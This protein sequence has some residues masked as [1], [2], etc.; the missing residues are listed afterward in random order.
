MYE[1]LRRLQI[2]E[3]RS[4]DLVQINEDTYSKAFIYIEQL[5]EKLVSKW[6]TQTIRELEN[7]SKVL[8][9]VEMRRAEKIVLHAFNEIYNG[10]QP[11]QGLTDQEKA[12]YYEVKDAIRRFKEGIDKREVKKVEQ[13]EDVIKIKVLK[14]VPKFKALDGNEY[15]PFVAG[16]L[17]ELPKNEGTIMI[18]RN[19]AEL[20]V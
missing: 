19:L 20:V 17:C 13:R 14:D 5:K 18:K 2:E 10:F 8:H 4:N 6:D 15:G 7:C 1:E 11:L 12:L 9:D 16:A 3:K